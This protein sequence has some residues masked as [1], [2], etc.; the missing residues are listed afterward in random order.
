MLVLGEAG[1]ARA[2]TLANAQI[3]HLSVRNRTNKRADL[4]IEK[5]RQRK[6]E[7][8]FTNVSKNHKLREFDLVINAT[9]VRMLP[10]IEAIL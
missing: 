9:S 7:I 5:L 10:Y 1:E 4:L 6:K 2:I 8:V 3:S